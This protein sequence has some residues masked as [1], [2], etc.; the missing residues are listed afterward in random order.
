MGLGA[1]PYTV[2]A[3]TNWLVKLGLLPGW[4]LLPAGPSDTGALPVESRP[5]LQPEIHRADPE[6]GS[7]LKLL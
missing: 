3:A 6:S 1:I 5:R 2:F 4:V 7:T